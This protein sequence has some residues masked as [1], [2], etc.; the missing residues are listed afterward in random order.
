[1]VHE[2]NEGSLHAT[3]PRRDPNGLCQLSCLSYTPTSD[4]LTEPLKAI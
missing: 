1:M 3:E 2:D 4:A